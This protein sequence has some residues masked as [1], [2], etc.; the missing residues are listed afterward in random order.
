VDTA[1]LFYQR[2]QLRADY[3]SFSYPI[4]NVK[5]TYVVHSRPEEWNIWN[6]FTPYAAS[7]WFSMGLMLIMQTLFCIYVARLEMRMGKRNDFKP[8]Q[9]RLDI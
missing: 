7:T 1:C 8:Y 2:T 6:A 9:V 4:T 5:P 3:F